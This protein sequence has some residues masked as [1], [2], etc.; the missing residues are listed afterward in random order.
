MRKL[1]LGTIL[2]CSGTGCVP[3]TQTP[4]E[5]PPISGA[6][7]CE[8]TRQERT[9]HAAALAETQDER[10]LMTGALLIRK[11]DAGCAS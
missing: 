10:V 1:L 9:A 4:S 2:W 6:V 3:V 11:L 5:P 8:E 7:I